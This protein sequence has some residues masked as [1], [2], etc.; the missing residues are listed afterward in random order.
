MAEVIAAPFVAR[1]YLI[2]EDGEFLPQSLIGKLDSLPNFSKWAKAV[3]SHPS[4][5]KVYPKEDILSGMKKMAAMK[6]KN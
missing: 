2:A 5:L 3:K 1:I 6:A 4:V